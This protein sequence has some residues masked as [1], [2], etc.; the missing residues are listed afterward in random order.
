MTVTVASFRVAFPEFASTAT[1]PDGEV[2]F[3]LDLSLLLLNAERWGNLFDYGQM[4]FVAHNLALQFNAK[5]ATASG[6]NPGNV[7]GP[8]TA[9]AVDKVSYSRNPGL[10][11]DAKH[12]H[13]NLTVYGLRYLDLVNMVGAGPLHVGVPLGGDQVNYYPQAWPGPIMGPY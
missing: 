2:Q 8:Q 9:G 10:V 11:M 12:G 13:W 4:L 1:Y 5:K 6:G 3:W 7:Q